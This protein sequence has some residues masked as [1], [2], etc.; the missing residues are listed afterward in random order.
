MRGLQIQEL[1]FEMALGHEIT[2]EDWISESSE[3]VAVA[4]DANENSI[5]CLGRTFFGGIN[6]NDPSSALSSALDSRDA[7]RSL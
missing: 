4:S 6:C 1:A 2:A 5:D 3:F 7:N